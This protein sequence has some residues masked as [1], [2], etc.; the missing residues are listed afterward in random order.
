LV[1]VNGLLLL[2]TGLAIV[3]V[4]AVDRPEASVEAL[5]RRYA[6]AVS[7]SDL[8]GA[9]AEIAPDQRST[10]H[11]WLSS[12]LGNVYD[13]R[14]IAVRSPSVVER[15]FRRVS[16]PTDVTVVLDVNRAFPGENY[17]PTSQVEVVQVDGRWYLARPLL[18]HQ[19]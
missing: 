1:L 9:L 14:G 5:V 18:A 4:I 3:A 15:V 16:G 8:D 19:V 7:S 10:Y 11:D 12:Q 6:L 13:V 2:L 17:Q